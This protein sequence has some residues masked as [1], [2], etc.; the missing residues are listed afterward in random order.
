[1]VEN[2][3]C[4]DSEQLQEEEQSSTEEASIPSHS[5]VLSILT[6]CLPWVEQQPETTP[7]QIF[8]FTNL[9][10]MAARKRYSSLKQGKITSYL[11]K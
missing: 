11:K 3:T 7:T 8:L 10:Y 6:Q 9:T 4:D 5:D 1:M 2:Q